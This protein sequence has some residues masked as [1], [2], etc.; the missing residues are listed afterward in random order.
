MVIVLPCN[1]FK[2]VS[3]ALRTSFAVA[4]S[5]TFNGSNALSSNGSVFR[6]P[7]LF[8]AS[9][10]A[11]NSSKRA[12]FCAFS[13][14]KRANSSV[15]AALLALA[16]AK[17]AVFFSTNAMTRRATVGKGKSL[18]FSLA[19]TIVISLRFNSHFQLINT[20]SGAILAGVVSGLWNKTDTVCPSV[21]SY[22]TAILV[23]PFFFIGA[24][25]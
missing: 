17:R 8:R 22:I 13:L 14:S 11:F 10:C 23:V 9:I 19:T 6:L 3:N 15:S 12:N 4:F 25:I 1:C 7:E 21:I 5:G 24:E 16:L 20:S 18:P 2:Y